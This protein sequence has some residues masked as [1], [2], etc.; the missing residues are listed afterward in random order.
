MESEIQHILSLLKSTFEKKAWYGPAVKEVLKDITADQA[1]HRLNNT[2][3]IIELVAHMTAWRIFVVKKLEG[4]VDYKVSAELNFP[5]PSNWKAAIQNLEESQAKLIDAIQHFDDSLLHESVPNSSY[6]YTFF[7][8]L[9]GIIHHDVY[10][11]GQ[12]ML[13]KKSK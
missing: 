1:S 6:G 5:S 9:H 12:I 10:H 13:L 2:H 7:T 11:I 4:N 8:F 3:S